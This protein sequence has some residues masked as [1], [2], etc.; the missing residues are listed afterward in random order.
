VCVC[1][2]VCVCGWVPSKLVADVVN[3]DSVVFV[4]FEV[5]LIED[6]TRLVFIWLKET[7][8]V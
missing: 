8:W 7:R 6:R 3:K 4:I 2:C 1:V 5:E